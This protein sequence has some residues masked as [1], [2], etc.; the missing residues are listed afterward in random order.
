MPAGG[1]ER[2][3]NERNKKEK[4]EEKRGVGGNENRNAALAVP[5][6]V[7]EVLK[8]RMDGGGGHL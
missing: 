3:M 4:V 8:G 1:L 2:G 6:R 5:D 7:L